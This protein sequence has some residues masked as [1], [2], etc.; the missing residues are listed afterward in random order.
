MTR[1]RN[2][3]NSGTF[4]SKTSLLDVKYLSLQLFLFVLTPSEPWKI[5][6]EKF[7]SIFDEVDVE[8]KI[9]ASGLMTNK[10]IKLLLH[11][12]WFWT[13]KQRTNHKIQQLQENISTELIQVAI[14]GTRSH[15]HLIREI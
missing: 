11:K 15:K 9:S 10:P 4:L 5:F 13:S 14:S 1:I 2:E 12:S 8:H 6:P 3:V 7:A